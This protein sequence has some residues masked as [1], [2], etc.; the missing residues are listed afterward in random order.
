LCLPISF[1]SANRTR[2]WPETAIWEVDPSRWSE[3]RAPTN[4]IQQRVSKVLQLRR[5]QITLQHLRATQIESCNSNLRFR[6]RPP[7]MRISRFSECYAFPSLT[8]GFRTLPTDRNR[9]PQID[10]T[11]P[12]PPA[13]AS[14]SIASV[15]WD[16]YSKRWA[17]DSLYSRRFSNIYPSTHPS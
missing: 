15:P 1:H 6:K 10:S 14:T 8:A 5:L 9:C 11:T 2:Y 16:R 3:C 12:S 13:I 17:R 4:I 7:L